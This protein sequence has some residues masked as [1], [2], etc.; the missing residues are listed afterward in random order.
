MSNAWGD[1]VWSAVSTWGGSVGRM[2][3]WL[4]EVDWDGDGLFDGINE[5]MTMIGGVRTPRLISLDIARGRM[6]FMESNG[7]NFAAID[8]GTV[9]LTLIDNDG[10]YNPFDSAGALFSYL[11]QNV[12]IRIRLQDAISKTF[13]FAFTGYID[14]IRPNF[15]ADISTV[16]I[17]ATDAQKKLSAKGLSGATVYTTE[18]YHEA[19]SQVLSDAG[20]PTAKTDIDTIASDTMPYW[21]ENGRSAWAQLQDLAAAAFGNLFVTADGKIKY[22]SNVATDSSVMTLGETHIDREYGIRV[23]GPREVVRNVIKIFAKA[24]TAQA[25]AVLWSAVDKPSIAPGQSLTVW[26]TFSYDGKEVPATSVTTPVATTD[27][28]ANTQA[29]GSG[30]DRTA[31]IA[32]VMTAFATTAKLVYTNNHASDTVYMTLMQV[33]GICITADPYTFAQAQD[34]DSIATYGERPFTIDTDWLQDI[35]T[36]VD[37]AGVL[38]I[39]LADPKQF[40]QI[41]VRHNQLDKAFTPELFNLGTVDFPSR[42]IS[43][44]LRLGYIHHHWEMAAPNVVD[45]EFYFEPNLFSNASGTWIFPALIGTTTKFP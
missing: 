8:P 25:L 39:R 10:R 45:T 16:T 31:D 29:N 38:K 26:A 4:V 23:P 44:E 22:M 30:T 15:S 14:D 2:L 42:S 5:A 11:Q 21:W 20:W 27:Y 43:D 36:A 3:T 28:T 6:F 35:N 7:T 33:R 17:T 24:R 19:I 37:R 40:P 18:Q 41:M 9:M 13:Y 34:N 12:L 1:A 32:V